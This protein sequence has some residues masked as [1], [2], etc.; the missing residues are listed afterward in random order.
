MVEFAREVATDLAEHGVEAEIIDLRTLA[1]LDEAAIG[2]SVAKTGRVAVFDV[3]WQ[4]FSLAA[5][6]SRL[7]CMNG[8]VRLVS[9]LMSFGQAW[10]HT[11]AG[12]FREYHHY[13]I[14]DEVV[15]KV[16]QAL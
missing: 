5:E 2:Q 3:G 14:R 1:P 11:P 8:A 16:L 12:C 15:T 4:R 10:E 7:I 9:P 6:V 13:P